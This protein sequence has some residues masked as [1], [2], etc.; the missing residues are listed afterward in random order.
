MSTARLFGVVLGA[1]L[2]GNALTLLG[3]FTARALLPAAALPSIGA[4]GGAAP[5]AAPDDA[6][7][8]WGAAI[9][10]RIRQFWV[11]PDVEPD[12]EAVVVNVRLAPGGAVVA[13]GVSV[14]TGSGSLE[15][16]QSVVAA[17]HDASPLP[18]PEGRAFEPFRDF[19]LS[20]RP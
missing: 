4:S 8:R 7:A 1:V 13:D 16:D 20:F 2:L 9:Q 10:E 15:F 14:V 5:R 18:V 19:D 3:V 6:A 12:T 17:V 11:R